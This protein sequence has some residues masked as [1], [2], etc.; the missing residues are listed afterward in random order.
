MRYSFWTDPHAPCRPS[1]E[2][3]RLTRYIA[4]D[5]YVHTPR[6]SRW[7]RDEAHAVAMKVVTR[8][9]CR[10]GSAA[11]AADTNSFW[12]SVTRSI[13]AC[14]EV[15]RR[16]RKPRAG[17]DGRNRLAAR[18]LRA[19]RSISCW[20]RMR[21][22]RELTNNPDVIAA[23]R[24]PSHWLSGGLRVASTRRI[25]ALAFST[26]T[27]CMSTCSSRPSTLPF[28]TDLDRLSTCASR[29]YVHVGTFHDRPLPSHLASTRRNHPAEIV[30]VYRSTRELTGCHKSRPCTTLRTSSRS[31]HSRS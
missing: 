11:E 15:R 6:M 16:G 22:A 4:G 12:A 3:V 24:S 25:I 23:S 18:R 29:S 2:D 8:S 7:R 17:E 9:A 10:E 31:P 5:C 13:S 28:N 27:G 14:R 26:E 1:A 21:S 30:R 19:E 20:S